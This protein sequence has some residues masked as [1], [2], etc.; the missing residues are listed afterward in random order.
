MTH[1]QIEIQ[2]FET[3]ENIQQCQNRDEIHS[4]ILSYIANFGFN[5]FIITDLP[6]AGFRPEPHIIMKNWSQDWFTHYIGNRLYDHD[7][8][9][10]WVER[11][12][13]ARLWS[14]ILEGH[15]FTPQSKRVMSDAQ[16]FGLKEG[17]IIP[18]WGTAGLRTCASLA[19]EHLELPPRS[20]DALHMVSLSAHEAAERV[21]Q[22]EEET[23]TEGKPVLTRREQEILRW[24]AQGKT[25]GEIATICNISANTAYNHV[26]S[27]AEKLDAVNRTH[28][29]AKALVHGE[30]NLL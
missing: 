25:D 1:N 23:F 8:I 15:E 22:P 7:P 13:Q 11:N 4:V 24:V 27:A 19:G 5:C 6:P 16:D 10:R 9:A 21:F 3:L 14:Q 26:K 2:A 30:I 29:V 28:A 12:C 17:F 18:L 20:Q